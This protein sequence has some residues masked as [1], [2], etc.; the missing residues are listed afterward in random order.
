MQVMGNLLRYM[1]VGNCQNK[2]KFKKLLQKKMVQFFVSHNTYAVD[3]RCAR[4][5]E[6]LDTTI[7]L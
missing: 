6:R 7:F 5:N 2:V 1:C 4:R 3:S